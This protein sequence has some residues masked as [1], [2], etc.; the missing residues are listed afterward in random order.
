MSEDRSISLQPRL[1]FDGRY[2]VCSSDLGV[3]QWDFSSFEILRQVFPF[4]RPTHA[5]PTRAAVLMMVANGDSRLLA[6]PGGLEASAHQPVILP[7][8]WGGVEDASGVSCQ[9]MPSHK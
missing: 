6:P 5:T 4:T 3:Y 2:I 1:Q 9:L 8:G 7:V